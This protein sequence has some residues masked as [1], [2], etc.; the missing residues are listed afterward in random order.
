[1]TVPE[2]T[3]MLRLRH[4]RIVAVLAYLALFVSAQV[5][6]SFGLLPGRLIAPAETLLLLGFV[7]TGALLIWID[8]SVPH[9]VLRGD[10]IEV[11]A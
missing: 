6:L 11:I 7:A 3:S 8:H 5:L 4:L 9:V 2:G 10:W 1:M